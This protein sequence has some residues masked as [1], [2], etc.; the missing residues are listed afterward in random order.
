MLITLPDKAA[1]LYGGQS[2]GA[3]FIGGRRVW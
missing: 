2:M 3:M 1:V